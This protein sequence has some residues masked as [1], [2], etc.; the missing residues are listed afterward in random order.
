M[1]KIFIDGGARV[2]ETL[3]CFVKKREDLIGCDYYL[4]EANPN[5]YDLL[6]EFA[7][8]KDYNFFVMKKALWTQDC[9]MNFYIANDVWGD[10]GS[11]L[12]PE[13]KEKLDRENPLKIEAINFSNFLFNNF[14]QDDYIIVKFDIEGAEYEIVPDLIKTGA[15]NLINEFYIEWHDNFFTNIDVNK[16]KNDL[17]SSGVNV[18]NWLF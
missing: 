12:M 6:D 17:N 7:K 13:K 5:Y 18:Y 15:I 4:F 8:N 3:D 16:I 10:V 9:E 14:S 2:G 11:T 1:K